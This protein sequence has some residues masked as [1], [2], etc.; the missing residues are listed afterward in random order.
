MVVDAYLVST[1]A[2]AFD[3]AANALGTLGLTHEPASGVSVLLTLFTLAN[4][5]TLTIG[6][7]VFGDP[8]AKAEAIATIQGWGKEPSPAERP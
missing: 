5:A 4:T 8:E 7:V 6:G 3:E 2:A 1:N